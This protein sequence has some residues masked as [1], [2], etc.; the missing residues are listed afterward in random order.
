MESGNGLTQ[1]LSNKG[2]ST[3]LIMG[4]KKNNQLAIM[5]LKRG[6][7]NIRGE[8]SFANHELS[9]LVPVYLINNELGKIA[10]E[11]DTILITDESDMVEALERLHEVGIPMEKITPLSFVVDEEV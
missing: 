8:I 9:G 11:V 2:V 4:E 10:E 3:I 6:N 7:I 1:I 5:E